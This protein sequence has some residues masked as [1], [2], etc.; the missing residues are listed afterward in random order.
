[1]SATISSPAL[2]LE[3]GP[4]K[5]TS[6][7]SP[8]DDELS[9]PPLSPSISVQSP[10]HRPHV[11]NNEASL[12]HNSKIEVNLGVEKVAKPTT[13]VKEKKVTSRKKENNANGNPTAKAI[14]KPRTSSGA[15]TSRKK[16]KISDDSNK[17]AQ[18]LPR[19]SKLT[20]LR[21]SPL[22]SH[23]PEPKTALHSPT[24]HD[25][26][27]SAVH[28]RPTLAFVGAGE[29]S[30]SAGQHY[31][32]IRSANM[33]APPHGQHIT[34]QAVATP[35]R[36]A[37]RASAS[38]SIA[39]LIDPPAMAPSASSARRPQPSDIPTST[40]I[41]SQ[42]LQTNR[43]SSSV[44]G[45]V[46]TPPNPPNDGMELD[47]DRT[48]IPKSVG[49]TTVKK[50][51]AGTSTG[52]SSTAQSPKPAR[53]KEAPPPLPQGNGLL[54]SS[55]FGGAASITADAPE[56]AAPTVVL[57]I[58]MKGEMNQYVNF[59]R[60]AEERYG[61]N[62]LHPRLAAQRERLA[63]VAAAGAA[64]EKASG[65][66]SADDMS[67]DLSEPESNVEMGGMEGGSEPGEKKPK[68]RT[69]ADQ[70]DKEDPF[71]DDSEMLW[72]EQAAASKDG[73]FVYSG[74]LV[75]EGEKPSIER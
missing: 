45:G 47:A 24:A 40:Q 8:E 42:S 21:E 13:S 19:Q 9:T 18:A 27:S 11:N 22:P 36:M 69:K 33:D 58:P 61:F 41:S 37:N 35:P 3:G 65:S 49:T 12:S 46:A 29:P 75:P 6:K 54:S 39:S 73:F 2:P 74:P 71:V 64:L 7:S 67:L 17:S 48:S 52:T 51:N 1:M 25:A 59:A 14:K 34:S 55:L 66:G 20:E 43:T 62:A 53:Q 70:Y 38:P 31:D 68:R 15:N 4:N 26:E 30:R 23:Q 56:K 16:Q 63:R 10:P 50:S 32:P 5:A 44:I 28:Q 60:M 72:E 57:H